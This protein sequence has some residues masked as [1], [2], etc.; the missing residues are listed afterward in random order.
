MN[1][2]LL[3]LVAGLAFAQE[4]RPYRVSG[5]FK[6]GAPVDR[7]ATSSFVTGTILT[8]SRWTGGP[9]AEFRLPARF[10]I[11]F[12]ALYRNRQEDFGGIV[13]RPNLDCHFLEVLVALRVGQFWFGLSF[14]GHLWSPEM[15]EEQFINY[16]RAVWQEGLR[17]WTEAEK[18]VH[19]PL[20]PPPYAQAPEPLTD[21][22]RG[23][24]RHGPPAS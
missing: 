17:K 8:E 11:G 24:T 13:G 9:T 21:M 4:D 14:F 12:E 7:P 3:F 10:A 23:R 1:R 19:G 5:G 16:L 22:S 2:I 20:S 6:I 15:T 18:V